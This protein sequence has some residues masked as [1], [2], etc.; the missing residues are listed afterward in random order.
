M[1]SS[2]W[3]S[4]IG[5]AFDDNEIGVGVF[6]ANASRGLIFRALITRERRRAIPELDHDVSFAGISF[7]G[8]KLSA[9]HDELRAE[10]LECRTGRGQIFGISLLVPNRDAHNPI[11]LWHLVLP[12]CFLHGRGWQNHRPRRRLYPCRSII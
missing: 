6:L 4:S 1:V 5:N 8:L 10:F 11:G 3:G 2:P 9:A 7:H 12:R